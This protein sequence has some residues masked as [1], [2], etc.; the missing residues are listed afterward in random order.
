MAD[1]LWRLALVLPLLLLGIVAVALVL[2]QQAGR[3]RPA[4]GQIAAAGAGGLTGGLAGKVASWLGG[5]AG[6]A[7]A[8]EPPLLMR[9][10]ALTPT[11]RV[12]VLRF[13]G[14]DHLLGVSGE[15]ML[16]IA[17]QPAPGSLEGAVAGS[18]MTGPWPPVDAAHGLS[19]G[20]T[21]T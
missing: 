13:G 6:V 21:R 7:K 15:A 16:L 19:Q 17:R 2:R 8:D 20:E 11:M 9:M 1:Y 3:R 4:H 10:E 12:A 14:C 5:H 18:D